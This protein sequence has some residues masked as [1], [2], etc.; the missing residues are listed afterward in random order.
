MKIYKN[1]ISYYKIIKKRLNITLIQFNNL[2]RVNENLSSVTES[3][4]YFLPIFSNFNIY[5][6][7]FIY[8]VFFIDEK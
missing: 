4:L 5:F 3:V 6:L 8:A 1:K 2:M 7:W